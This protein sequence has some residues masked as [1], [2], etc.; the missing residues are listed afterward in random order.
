MQ[1]DEKSDNLKGLLNGFFY[2]KKFI[3]IVLVLTVVFF[4]AIIVFVVSFKTFYYLYRSSSE[5]S[6]YSNGKEITVSIPAEIRGESFLDQKLSVRLTQIVEKNFSI[7]QDA[8]LFIDN[9]FTVAMDAVLTATIDQD[10]YLDTQIPLDVKLPVDGIKV[11][12]SFLNILDFKIPLKGNL[13]YKAVIPWKGSVRIK[14]VMPIRV[15]QD[16][17]FHLKKR[18]RLPLDLSIKAQIP[19]DDIFNVHFK[20]GV[21]GKSRVTEPFQYIFNLRDIDNL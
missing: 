5:K 18:L 17:S 10:V 4:V 15:N 11:S 13:L 21:K 8:E 14:T 6:A 12:I 3:K 2:K 1:Q 19:I 20:G 16:V 7:N 9:D